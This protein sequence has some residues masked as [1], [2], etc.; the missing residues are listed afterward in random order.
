[1]SSREFLRHAVGLPGFR[2]TDWVY[3]AGAET[4]VHRHALPVLSVTLTGRFEHRS[5]GRPLS[6][7]AATAVVHPMGDPHRHRA[8]S[9]RTRVLAIAADNATLAHRGRPPGLLTR[10]SVVPDPRIGELAWRVVSEMEGRDDLW[11]LAVE[12]LLLEMLAVVARAASPCREDRPGWLD[13]VVEILHAR[14]AEPLR[15]AD[16]VEAVADVDG[17]EL[18]RRFRRHMH[19]SISGYVR[20][21]RLERACELLAGSEDPIAVVAARAGFADQS[22]LTRELSRAFGTTPAAYRRDRG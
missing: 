22:H 10:R 21:L 4:A 7:I 2:V 13:D 9:V 5:A 8:G 3:D 6:S 1:M 11:R 16:L 19:T 17:R 18:A 14:F 12:G 15:V 20:R